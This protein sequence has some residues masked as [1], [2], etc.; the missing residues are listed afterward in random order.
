MLL[1]CCSF[2]SLLFN[3][4]CLTPNVCFFSDIRSPL[5]RVFYILLR[6]P[7]WVSRWPDGEPLAGL[8]PAV[9][10][11]GEPL[12]YPIGPSTKRSGSLFDCQ[13][14]C[15]NHR[16]PV[17]PYYYFP[18]WLTVKNTRTKCI[19]LNWGVGCVGSIYARW[20]FRRATTSITGPNDASCIIWGH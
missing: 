4:N 8:R 1:L 17:L 7:W 11:V 12:A 6:P 18:Y 2:E 15:P 9:A 20:R 13:L 19:S 3:H 5:S 14:F 10:I 16:T